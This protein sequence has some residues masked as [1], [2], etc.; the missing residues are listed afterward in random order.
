[1]LG[2]NQAR[3]VFTVISQ[4][5]QQL[6]CIAVHLVRAQSSFLVKES[7]DNAIKELK[8]TQRLLEIA[9]SSYSFKT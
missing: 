4:A 7:L 6:K 2:M 8:E 1:M 5:N 3:G 9:K